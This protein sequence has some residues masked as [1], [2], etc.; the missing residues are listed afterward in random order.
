LPSPGLAGP[1]V[2]SSTGILLNDLLS[3]IFQYGR[4]SSCQSGELRLM[5][6]LLYSLSLAGHCPAN[7]LSRHFSEAVTYSRRRFDAV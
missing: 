6:P 4:I 5:S 1:P 3:G 7:V 2:Y